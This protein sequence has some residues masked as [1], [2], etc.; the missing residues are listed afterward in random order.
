MVGIA[1]FNLM[2]TNNGTIA[3][4][5]QGTSG[6]VKECTVKTKVIALD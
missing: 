1:G 4:F 5:E 6:N 2:R 3:V